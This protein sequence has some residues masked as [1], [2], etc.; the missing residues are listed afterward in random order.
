MRAD[1]LIALL[2]LLQDRGCVPA[3]ELSIEL[4]VSERTIYRDVDALCTAG[5][6]VYAERGPGGGFG[7]LESYRSQLNGLNTEEVRAL[8]MIGVPAPVR[9]LGFGVELNTALRKLSASLPESIR[10]EESRTRE[11]VLVDADSTAVSAGLANILHSLRQALWQDRKVL[12]TRRLAFDARIEQ[13]AAPYGLVASADAWRLVAESRGFIQ[14]FPVSQILAVQVLDER[15]ERP[16]G[17]VLSGFWRRW[18]TADE[19]RKPDYPV[20][21]RAA[22]DILPEL[23]RQFGE[24]RLGLLGAQAEEGPDDRLVLTLSF[25]CLESARGRLLAY[26]RAVE[27]LAPVALRKSIADY[28]RQIASL[29]PD[30]LDSAIFPRAALGEQRQS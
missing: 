2:F 17:F 19:Q 26:G 8:F 20:K 7:L 29:Y 28:A 23:K 15:F 22:R 13:A 21:V 30:D 12:L 16:D 4:E 27:V 11:R 14:V 18:R 24:D 25:D 6:P 3:H 5:V 10:G 9:E 1:R